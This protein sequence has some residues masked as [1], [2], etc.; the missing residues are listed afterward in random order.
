MSVMVSDDRRTLIRA[1]FTAV[2]I[3]LLVLT[4]AGWNGHW[5]AHPGRT[6]VDTSNF[7]D[8]Q[9]YELPPE[10]KLMDRLKPVAP[11]RK[12]VAISKTVDRGRKAEPQE[13]HPVQDE[14]QTEGGPPL[15]ATH[16][17][18]AIFSPAPKIPA[19]LQEKELH[20][21]VVIDFFVSARGVA[22]PHLVG[23]SGNEELDALAIASAKQWRFRPGEADHK[24]IDAK[25]R[26]RILFEVQ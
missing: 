22:T 2:A 20:A 16:G 26:L 11:I 12:E 19:Y 13:E 24:P 3:E 10:A 23:S 6:E 4:L 25:V 21:S 14:N 9:I 8:A 1:F 7:I 17:P 18:V 15:A 5:L